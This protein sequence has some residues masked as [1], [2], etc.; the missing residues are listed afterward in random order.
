MSAAVDRRHFLRV[1]GIA[2]GGLLIGTQLDYRLPELGA[3]EPGADADFAPNAFLRI[4]RDGQVTII[5]KNPEVGQGVKTSLPQLIADELDVPWESVTIEQADS[6]PAKYGPQ[7][8][9]GSTAT[10]T[11]WEPLRRAGAVGRA[12]MISAA[13]QVWNV[14]EAECST[15]G[16]ARVHHHASRRVLR[17]AELAERAAT[18]PTPDAAAVRMKDPKDYRIIGKPLGGVDNAKIVRGAPLFGIDVSV[19]GMLHAQYIK[20]PVFGARVA[21]ANLDAIKQ[22][23]G[24]RDAFV[25]EG[26]T[27]LNGLLPGVA[28]VADK[29]WNARVARNALRVTWAEHPTAQQSNTSFKRQAQ[30]FL[31]GAPQRTLVRVGEA[32]P[33]A[34]LGRVV[35]AEYEYP[36]LAHAALE[37]MNCT[38]HFKDGKLEVWAPTQ[39]PQSGR[40]LCANTLGI[41]PEDITIHMIRG[42]GGFGRRL[43]N[44]YMVEA[45]AIA[46]QVGAPVKLTWT[47]EDDLQHDFYRPA[48]YHKLRGAVDAQGNL[49]AWDN[50]FVTF[51]EGNSFA[52]AAG[53]SLGEFPAGFVPNFHLGVSTM[54]LG[55]PTGF[56]RAPTSNAIAFVYQSFLDELALA[57]GRDPVAFRLDLL[58]K[59]VAPPPP[60]GPGPRPSYMDPARMRGVLERVAQMSAWGT[61]TLPRGKG[62]GVGFHFSHRGYFAEVVEVTV[63]RNGTLTVDKVWVAGDVGSVIINPSGAANQVRGSVLDG[64]AEA[65]NQQVTI[66]GGAARESNFTTYPLLRIT[67][68]PPVEIDFV[69]SDVPPTGMGEPALPPVIPALT[70]AI[71]AATGKRIRSLPLSLH[72]LS[73]S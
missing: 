25:I 47:R 70:N 13:A 35:E 39:N 44:D 55:V 49:V 10:P 23:R 68:T 21:S 7:V 34:A 11:N 17:Y 6:D 61:R 72:D 16:D 40:T 15:S 14:P 67:G 57:A 64:I 32:G 18:L 53:I 50:H 58:G 71:F 29:Y 62:M 43:N 59:F 24:V 2:G 26:T 37:P 36:F 1:T 42:G 69:L 48:G 63:A 20:A 41:A 22:M 38:A 12:L 65:L 5:A 31:R 28:I 3:A 54:P 56:L 33:S 66:E 46:K 51:G 19:P 8:A 27:Q 73:W 30:E 60:S 4:T 9:G 52:P 45:A